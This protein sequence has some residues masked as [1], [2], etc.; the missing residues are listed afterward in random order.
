[1]PSFISLCNE[2]GI[3]D[4]LRVCVFVFVVVEVECFGFGTFSFCKIQTAF[5]SDLLT[6]K[7]NWYILSQSNVNGYLSSMTKSFVDCDLE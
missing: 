4:Y 5:H 3:Q 2:T 6:G 7:N 1:M